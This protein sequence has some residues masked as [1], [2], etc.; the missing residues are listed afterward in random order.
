M[1]SDNEVAVSAPL[2][3][4]HVNDRRE[5]LTLAIASLQAQRRLLGDSV[6]DV[7]LEPLLRELAGLASAQPNQQ[8]KQVTVLFVDVVGSTAIGQGLGPEDIHTVMDRALARFTKIVETHF[9]RVLQYTGDGM[10]AAFGSEAAH[11]D[12]VES[13][14]HAGLAIIEDSK[15]QGIE[16]ERRL[17]IAD[18]MVRAGLHT[19]TVLLGGGVDA[20]GSIR[21]ATVNIAARMEQSAPS[22]KLR[23]SHESY[24]H[25]RGL[26]EVSEPVMVTVKGVEHPL[27]SYVVERAK[28]R[29]FRFA[30]RGIEGVRPR[31]VGR[32][33]ELEVVKST[34]AA[35]SAER[36]SHALT[37]VGEAGVGKSRL[38][39]EFQ[40]TLDLDNCW[41][42][43]GRAHPRS[44][45][46]PYG[47]L[48]DMLLGQMQI[49]EG[50]SGDAARA[51]LV[52]KLVPLF[53]A[54]G[55]A[56]I[57]VIG[58]LIG[59]D[60][61]ASPHV[62]ELLGDERRFTD[63]ALDACVLCL[64]RLG[65]SRPVV[66][67][68]DDLHWA[69][70][71]TLA[72][73]GRLLEANR[74]TPLLSL[75]MTRPIVFERH[76]DWLE[77]DRLHRRLDLKP[78]DGELSRQ[79]ADALLQRMDEIPS[80]LRA[81]VTAGAEGNPFYMEELVKML[82]DDG[83]I[84]IEGD[85][86]RVS[87][88]RLHKA[89]VP[90]TLTGVLQARL[91]A[92]QPAERA[93]LQNA[94]IVGH[95]FW[96]Q[97]LAAIDPDALAAIPV[98]LRKQLVIHRDAGL[99]TGEYSFQHHLLH[100]VTY[101][102][103]LREPRRRGHELAGAFWSQLAEVASPRHVTPAACRALAE[104]HD[105]RRR[106]DPATVAAWFDAQFFNYF[107]AHATLTLRPL[108]QNV[109]EFCERQHG[110]EHIETARALTNLARIAVLQRDMDV[111]E[112]TL[113]RALAIQERELGAEHLDTVRTIAVLGGFYQGRGDYAAAEPL[114]RRV[115]EVRE[116]A[117][118]TDHPLT[119]GTLRLLTYVLKE[120]DNLDEA[121]AL[122]RRLWQAHQR[123]AGEA[124][125]ATV[126]AIAM[127][128]EVLAKKGA[129]DEAEPLLRRALSVQEEGQGAEDPDTGL[130]AWHLAETL[131]ALGQF[132]EA[133]VLARRSLDLWE[134]RLGSEHEW[135]AWGL[136]CLAEVRLAL[137]AAAEA[138]D[139]ADRAARILMNLFGTDHAALGS[140]LYLQGRALLAAGRRADADTVL[141]Q[142]LNIQSQ[143]G[144]T[145]QAAS[146]A[147]LELLQQ[148]RDPSPAKGASL[149]N[150]SNTG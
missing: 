150:D 118:G 139:G 75:I 74:D 1:L 145:A 122:G 73:M 15:S 17:G 108:A 13:A 7:V 92:L 99:D 51:K 90:S 36:S 128:G 133:E 120:L 124:A 69:D 84:E 79:L 47:V 86:W 88:D 63:R 9:G 68:L 62:Q 121:E 43:L 134:R 50:D 115:L 107:H 6:V 100:Q 77:G 41:L 106:A 37:I 87:A 127:V 148:L 78:L 112:P 85:R 146:E 94:A 97:A 76:I 96:D 10:L 137:G 34:F 55:E 123:T 135:T 52:S 147:T 39:A 60:F 136:V 30:S 71:E 29:A 57:H 82:I 3:N 126:S 16:I 103:V 14:V 18:F 33:S 125:L 23:V 142:A 130:T 132:N 117:L 59:L 138:V 8:L 64:R 45:L 54:E 2:A 111:A 93:A 98:L 28:P 131:R 129:H 5:Q 66:V 119:L 12:D 22:G 89:R 140:T 53:A 81:V 49:G 61:S 65:E 149:L 19:G 83:V 25:I 56:P 24:R 21:G 110:S 143:L 31:M 38:L 11:E 35:T 102:G 70:A 141:R 105:H 116:R 72:F 48:R 101:D 67:V 80:T 27:R 26:F 46:H 44:A 104:A 91:D 58:H 20:E 114:F 109:V 95:V 40:Q 42:L 32:E 144:N 4:Q 113:R